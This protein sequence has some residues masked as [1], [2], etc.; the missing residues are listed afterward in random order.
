MPDRVIVVGAG[1]SGLT[2]AYELT[3]RA[4]RLPQGIDLLCL[5]AGPHP[6][7]N[8]RTE[9]AEGFT[10]EAGPTGFLDNAPATLTLVRRLG[11]EPR[12]LPAGPRANDRFIY[13]RRRLQRIP[14]GAF[15]F[16]GTRILSPWGKL[17]L[18][19]EPLAPRSRAADESVLQFASRRIG[20]QAAR[21]LVDAMVSGVF[22]GN[23]AELSLPAC[24]PKM[25]E[26]ESEHGSLFR[27][28]LAR[29]KE[30]QEEGGGPAGPGG[31]LTSF[32]DGLQELIDALAAALGDRLRTDCRVQQISDLGLRGFRVVSEEGAP[33]EADAVVLACPAWSAA[34][35]VR[36]MDEPLARSLGEIEGAPVNV[37]HFGYMEGALGDLPEGFGFL[38]P[39]GQGPR[40]LGTLWISSIF[41]GRA[42]ADRRLMTTMVGG[43]HDPA[44][45][46]LDDEELVALVRQDLQTTMGI[47]AR[48]YFVRIHRW[49]R[50]IPQY[51]IGHPERMRRIDECLERHPGLWLTGNAYRGVAMNACIE[52]APG[53]AERVLEFLA[54]A[55]D[56][57]AL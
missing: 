43:A 36:S 39:R 14:T 26:M 2:T 1:I 32:R 6:G 4:E 22:A 49:P 9:H 16:L 7:G 18:L 27:A 8:I 11:L 50:G 54:T 3:Q 25:R 21:I 20:G 41:E 33:L 55:S 40:I 19:A 34:P 53:V 31:R 24:F 5:E 28:M 57:A 30:R 37:V 10:F 52:E 51:T 42:P 12:L 35:A 13:C 56:A 48:P 15:S 38:V 29:R 23:A 17:R 47:T 44:A 46:K 45:T